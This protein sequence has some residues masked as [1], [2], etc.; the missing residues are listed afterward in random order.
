MGHPVIEVVHKASSSSGGATLFGMGKGNHHSGAVV[1]P[2]SRSVT[3][4]SVVVAVDKVLMV[5]I[6]LHG[7]T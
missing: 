3:S 2:S 1:Y 5:V 7:V 4:Q 6:S